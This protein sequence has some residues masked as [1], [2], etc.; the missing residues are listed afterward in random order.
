MSVVRDLVRE[1]ASTTCF[2]GKSKG[3][4]KTFCNH[5]FFSLPKDVRRHLY[6]R[7][8]S[9]YEQAYAKSVRF[10]KGEGRGE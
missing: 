6:R 9:G 7:I 1:L 8:G 3:S 4:G 10:L 2:C 5:C